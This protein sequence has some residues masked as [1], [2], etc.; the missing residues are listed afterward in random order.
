MDIELGTKFDTLVVTGPNTGGKTAV[1][2]TLGTITLM[3]QT[4]FHIPAREGSVVDWVAMRCVC[5][6]VQ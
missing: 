2:K 3:A 6:C 4:G 1:L 5:S